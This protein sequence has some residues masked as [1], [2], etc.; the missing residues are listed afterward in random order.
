V[1]RPKAA[2]IS[3]HCPVI[4]IVLAAVQKGGEERTEECTERERRIIRN[5]NGRR[6]N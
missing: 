2:D 3:K 6:R 5:I 1:N 4:P